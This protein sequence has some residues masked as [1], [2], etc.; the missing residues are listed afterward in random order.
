M[1]RILFSTILGFL[2]G[3]GINSIFHIFSLGM[4][5]MGV[6]FVVAGLLWLTSQVLRKHVY[7]LFFIGSCLIGV[8]YIGNTFEYDI[9]AQKSV[10]KTIDRQSTIQGVVMQDPDMRNASK[11][12][13]IKA[14]QINK[15]NIKGNIKILVSTDRHEN[16]QYGDMV[17][18]KGRLDNPSN[19]TTDTNREFDYRNYLAKDDIFYQVFRPDIQVLGYGYGSKITTWM[20][21]LKHV[22]VRSLNKSFPQPE[23]ALLAGELFGEKSALGGDLQDAFRRTGVIHIVV[24]SGFN[25]TIVALFMIWLLTRFL[26][27]RVALFFGIASIVLFAVLVGG[28]S[29]VIRASVMA[30][31]VIIA[32]LIGREYDVTRGLFLAAFF[33]VIINPKILAFDI[34]FQLSFLATLSLIYLSPVIEKKLQWVTGTFQLREI[35]IQTLAAQVFVLPLL[36]YSIGE[37]SIVSV[38]VNI[39]V[40][41]LVPMSMLFGFLTS[42]VGLIIPPLAHAVMI[43]GYFL[44]KA[45]LMIVNF[46][47]SFSFAAITIP[48]IPWW[49]V[50]GLY[51]LIGLWI[52]KQYKH[53]DKNELSGSSTKLKLQLQKK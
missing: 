13:V 26:H 47:N 40:V 33:M 11:K 1:N 35:I 23:G 8:F 20:L 42:V 31:L 38:L 25:I 9:T 46:F 49:L 24:L 17:L 18:I 2:L 53:I 51:T 3:V 32:R 52:M 50:F 36:I 6:L 34:S 10:I 16:I 7:V 21:S 19:F 22:L 4:L 30:I 44:L 12:I 14:R 29:T 45:Q 43:P 37:F 5:I 15:K 41:P 48:P 27:P 39:L 28:G